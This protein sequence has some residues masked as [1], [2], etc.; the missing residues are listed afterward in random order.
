MTETGSSTQDEPRGITISLADQD[1]VAGDLAR[2][3]AEAPSDDGRRLV[4]S[5]DLSSST[6]RGELKL[7]SVRF[8]WEFLCHGARFER[9]VELHDVRS[10]RVLTLGEATYKQGL[11]IV[12]VQA[13]LVLART[14]EVEGDLNVVG[15]KAEGVHL[16]GA[17]VDGA[18]TIRDVVTEM[19]ALGA[20]QAAGPVDIRSSI[21]TELGV[22]GATFAST[23]RIAASA[24]R[25]T[26]RGTDFQ[27]GLDLG[28]RWAEIALDETR[29][30]AP[31]VVAFVDEDVSAGRDGFVY[32]AE[33]DLDERLE[34]AGRR[35]RPHVVS[36]RRANL[37]GLLL[38][39]VDLHACRFVKAHNLD[40]LRLEND[41][42]FVRTNALPHAGSRHVISEEVHWRAERVGW[43]W[44]ALY[45]STCKP[46]AW[47]AEQDRRLDT[48]FE[49]SLVASIYRSLRKGREDAK[50]EPG[51]ADFYYGEMEMRR[52]DETAPLAERAILWLYWLVSGYG[53]RASRALAALVAVVLVF[54]V[55]LDLWGFDPDRN[56]GHALLVSIQS[57]TA[58]LR[59]ITEP[60]TTAGEWAVTALRLLGPLLL[61][62]M[63]L[64]LRG[65]VKR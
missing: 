20:L 6:V 65:R 60:L 38:S 31:S 50:D 23:V 36:L 26:A 59:G 54:A 57:T 53:L 17:K 5:L 44:D 11:D 22:D 43:P 24:D 58:L 34:L 47:L 63:I 28:A 48:A 9:R 41:V 61:G 14:L 40:R 21:V 51:A 29:F 10:D 3:I 37:E 19:L 62:L 4:H 33:A 25:I 45:E 64:S 56:F 39:G 46:P 49:A 2:Q 1:V 27:Q 7:Q 52:H 42:G 55:V 13:P 16:G 8:G 30:G 12:D 18:I 35:V 32:D 15:V